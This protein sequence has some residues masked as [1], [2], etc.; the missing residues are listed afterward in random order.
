[1]K[2]LKG[3]TRYLTVSEVAAQ[4]GMTTARVCQLIKDGEITASKHGRDWAILESEV[5]RYEA[6]PKDPRGRP[7]TG[8]QPRNP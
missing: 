8:Q 2:M 7:R 1:M 6:K 5:A 3:T 4:L